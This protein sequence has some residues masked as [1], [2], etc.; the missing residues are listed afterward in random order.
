MKRAWFPPGQES[1][2]VVVTFKIHSGGELSHLRLEK[3]SGIA[4]VDTAALTALENAV[5]FRPLP[6]TGLDHVNIRLTFD[7]TAFP[8]GMHAVFVDYEKH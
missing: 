2:T 6:V 7:Y 1:R 4:I 8:D 5:P 3:S